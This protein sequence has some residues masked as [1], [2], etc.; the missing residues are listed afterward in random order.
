MAEASPIS[1]PSTDDGS[2]GSVESQQHHLVESLVTQIDPDT[3]NRI[4]GL[5]KKSLIRFEK[6]N[7][8]LS[9][10]CILSAKRLEKAKKELNDSKDLIV[11]MKLD[12]ESVFRRIRIFKKNLIVRYPE[13]SKQFEPLPI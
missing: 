2:G 5:Q 12:L 11:Q 7:E 4:I 3:I 8:M 13:V 10:C 1:S 9:N 6:T